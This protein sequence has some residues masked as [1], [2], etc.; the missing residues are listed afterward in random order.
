M[1][2]FP[3]IVA[4]TYRNDEQNE[5]HALRYQT[6]DNESEI[7]GFFRGNITRIGPGAYSVPEIVGQ[8][9]VESFYPNCPAYSFTKE[10]KNAAKKLAMISKELN[11]AHLPENI[12]GAGAY[13]PEKLSTVHKCPILKM[14]KAKRFLNL[15]KMVLYKMNL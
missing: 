12:P 7:S 10:K 15:N 8:K 5:K 3:I 14:T 11:S 6:V 13:N 4:F 2:K 1:Y 9:R